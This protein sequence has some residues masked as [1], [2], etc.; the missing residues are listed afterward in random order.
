MI[1]YYSSLS[2]SYICKNVQDFKFFHGKYFLAFNSVFTRDR[3]G[4]RLLL[5]QKI[6]E[7]Y[8]EKDDELNRS[9]AGEGKHLALRRRQ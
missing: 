6:V 3:G 5:V 7:L 2:K 4:A 1:S 8:E 9:T